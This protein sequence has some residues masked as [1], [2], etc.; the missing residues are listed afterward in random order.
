VEGENGDVNG[1]ASRLAATAENGNV[2]GGTPADGI[3]NGNS[4]NVNGSREL[5]RRVCGEERQAMI[6]RSRETSDFSRMETAMVR[7]SAPYRTE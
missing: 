5:G 2:N 3:Y 1:A 6:P 4:A 7:Y